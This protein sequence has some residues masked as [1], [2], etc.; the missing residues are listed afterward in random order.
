MIPPATGRRPPPAGRW[1]LREPSHESGARLFC[2]PFAGTGAAS[3]RGWPGRIGPLEV[4]P[5]QLPG[6]ENRIRED[7]YRDFDTF[8][9]DASRA[10]APYLDRPY[11][12]FGHCMGALL[13]Y[14][15]AVRIQEEGGRLP[16]RL[17]LSSCLVPSRGFF[18]MFHPS[19]SDERLGRELGRVVRRLGGGEILPDLLPLAIRVL[20][21][22]VDMCYGY[23]PPGPYPLKSPISAIGWRDDPDV[24][25]RDLREWDAYGQVTHHTLD[26][27]AL[28]YLTA[29]TAL[30]ELIAEDFAPA[31]P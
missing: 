20:R 13:C 18:G 16:D 21:G 6:R 12:L 9:A 4:C 24:G 8:A 29:P 27:D 15:L 23:R 30:T 3:F 28:A 5:V 2:L 11:A 31:A 25:P 22:D 17:Y 10:L 1:L 14:A 19:M 7:G 26:G